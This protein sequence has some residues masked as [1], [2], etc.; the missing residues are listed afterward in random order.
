MSAIAP[1][2]RSVD[3]AMSRAVDT[4]VDRLRSGQD[5]TDAYARVAI[6]VVTH[7]ADIAV[8]EFRSTHALL[9]DGT[10]V[11]FDPDLVRPTTGVQLRAILG[12]KLRL[13]DLPTPCSRGERVSIETPHGG[14]MYTWPIGGGPLLRGFNAGDPTLTTADGSRLW[15]PDD[16]RN[17]GA[18]VLAGPAGRVWLRRGGTVTIR[19]AA[20]SAG[21]E[22]SAA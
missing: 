20:S 11:E 10:V 4:F 19:P 7:A 6:D 5:L 14:R 17:R 18:V 3:D 1:V 15:S 21:V 13:R 16:A 9:D 8:M 2:C 12:V 22:V